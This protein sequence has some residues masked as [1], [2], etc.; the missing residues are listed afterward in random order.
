[1]ARVKKTSKTVEVA[2]VRLASV[3]SIDPNL[4]LGNGI[5]AQSFNQLIEETE[6]ALEEY[7]TALSLADEKKNLFD[8]KEKELKDFHERV[9]NGVGF[10]FGKDSNEYEKAGGVKKSDRKKPKKKKEEEK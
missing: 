3:K 2:N 10:K 7:N 9:L 4:D 5:S 8:A 6:A 1:M